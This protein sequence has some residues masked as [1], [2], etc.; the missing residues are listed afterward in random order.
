[1]AVFILRDIDIV[2]KI[3]ECWSR[4]HDH[5]EVCPSGVAVGSAG[6]RYR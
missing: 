6:Q 1:M 2:E 5:D 4:F 3:E